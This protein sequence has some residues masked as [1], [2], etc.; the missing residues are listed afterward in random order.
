[1][2][3]KAADLLCPARRPLVLVGNG[4]IRR[5][6]SG[7]GAADALAALVDSLNLPVTHTFMGKGCI[8]YRNPH[9]LGTV[10]LQRP[11]ADLAAMPQLEE[12]DLVLTI[13]YDLVEWSPVP[14]EPAPRQRDRAH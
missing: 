12:A 2:L 7:H 14:V 8:D 3:E 13:G 11:G 10:G 5:Q 9:S 4:V 6:A 1:M